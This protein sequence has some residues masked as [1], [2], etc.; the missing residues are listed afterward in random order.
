[1]S[2]LLLC[3][4]GLAA[5]IA[6]VLNPGLGLFELL[7]DALPVVGNLDE[8]AATGLAIACGREIRRL[9]AAR[10]AASGGS[11]LQPSPSQRAGTPGDPASRS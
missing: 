1:M 3:W 10:L 11:R 5:S 4:I 9:R 2:R 8:A 6:Y 7:P